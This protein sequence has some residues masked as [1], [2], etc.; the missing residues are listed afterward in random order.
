MKAI[1]IAAYG[2]PEVMELIDSPVPIPKAGEV[3]IQLHCAGINYSDIS[4]RTGK[5]GGPLPLI[6]GSEGA[7]TIVALGP[8]VDCLAI[9]DRVA[10]WN[11]AMGSYAEFAVCPEFRV[12]KLPDRMDFGIG[13]A[14]ML[15][16]LTA[17]YLVRSVF[18]VEKE[19]SLLFHAGAGGV[20][21]IVIQLAK[22]RGARVLTTVGSPEKAA[23]VRE[24]GADE[25]ILYGEVNFTEA[26]RG[27]TG[28]EGVDVVYDAVGA[29]TWEGS[30]DCLKRRGTVVYFG[31]ASG[32]VP[33]FDTG[34]LSAKGSLSLSR[35]MLGDFVRDGKEIAWR[36]GELFDLWTA[37]ELKIRIGQTYPL[38][39]AA[40]A[41]A[42]L[43]N[44]RTT[45]KL[46][47]QP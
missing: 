2:G 8:D 45:G 16:G 19:H 11:P 26:V 31:G 20:G 4:W 46:L 40:R 37:G 28:G 29:A 17:H 9:G 7:G 27:L 33:A 43:E 10:Y 23:Y 34:I 18:P 3:L 38:E 41:H 22:A 39:Q 25:A 32:P 36:A 14:L 1:Q 42:D 6:N 5:R 47:L 21:Q 13:A 15:Q 12:V 30:L 24:I 35:P 44:R